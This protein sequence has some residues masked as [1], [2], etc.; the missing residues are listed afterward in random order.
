MDEPN[1]LELLRHPAVPEPSCV[2]VN[3]AN[4]HAHG[5]WLLDDPVFRGKNADAGLLSYAEA[6]QNSLT[7]VTMGDWSFQHGY[8]RNPVAKDPVGEMWWSDRGHGY[9]LAELKQHM[10]EAGEWIAGLPFARRQSEDFAAQGRN[11]HVFDALMPKAREYVATGAE[12]TVAVAHKIARALNLALPEPMGEGEVAVIARSSV[13]QLAKSKRASRGG[14]WV[15]RVGRK[16]GRARTEAKLQALRENGLKGAQKLRE[17]TAARIRQVAEL[18]AQGLDKAAIMAT[19]GWSR[20]TVKKYMDATTDVSESKAAGDAPA[21]APAPAHATKEEN[22]PKSKVRKKKSTAKKSRSLSRKA[23][24]EAILAG[25]DPENR[26]VAAELEARLWPRGWEKFSPV[27]WGWPNTP[28]PTSDPDAWYSDTMIFVDD[29]A[30]TVLAP[31]TDDTLADKQ[32]QTTVKFDRV[33]DLVHYLE[34]IE[35]GRWEEFE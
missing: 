22:V 28:P 16:G 20:N 31:L 32:L 10:V 8:M 6:V 23:T 21:G 9:R 25:Q 34:Y 2:Q 15:A 4:G 19:T 30:I 12:Y 29:G 14:S 17:R 11:C 1:A 35:Q 26:A 27:Q 18:V 13:R 24:D 5:F 7:H 3:P 33:I